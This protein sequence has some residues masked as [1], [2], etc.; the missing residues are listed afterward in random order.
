MPSPQGSPAERLTGTTSHSADSQGCAL[1]FSGR[2]GYKSEASVAV[3]NNYTVDVSV[4]TPH[5][6]PWSPK[7]YVNDGWSKG[8]DLIWLW[9]LKAWFDGQGSR[10]WS[11]FLNQMPRETY[12][13]LMN[14]L[15]VAICVPA[16]CV[17]SP[18]NTYCYPPPLSNARDATPSW[19]VNPPNFDF[20]RIFL[21]GQLPLGVSVMATIG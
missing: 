5:K 14:E 13:S 21:H 12:N 3:L 2:T 1:G 9:S 8:I 16:G 6:S 18:P 17:V 10:D 20:Q 15:L 11:L 7:S 19:T 4:G